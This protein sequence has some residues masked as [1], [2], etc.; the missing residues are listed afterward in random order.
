MMKHWKQGVIYKALHEVGD[1]PLKAWIEDRLLSE[2]KDKPEV[3]DKIA[4]IFSDCIKKWNC[5]HKDDKG[6]TIR[7]MPPKGNEQQPIYC[8][9]CEDDI[10]EELQQKFREG[11]AQ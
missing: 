11:D 4:F 8:T 9:Q 5:T 2:F 6:W 10:T 1:D 3:L 7:Q